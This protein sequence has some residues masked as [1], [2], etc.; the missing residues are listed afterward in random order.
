MP[1]TL[2]TPSDLTRDLDADHQPKKAKAGDKSGALSGSMSGSMSGS[3]SDTLSPSKGFVEAA[4]DST[5]GRVLPEQAQQASTPSTKQANRYVGRGLPPMPKIGLE[6]DQYLK[7]AKRAE[8]SGDDLLHEV[9]KVG[10]YVTLAVRRPDEKWKKK[11][12]FFHHALKRHCQA[13]EHADEITKKW[14]KKLAAFVRHH[15]GLEALRI[16][17]EMNDCFNM[18]VEMGQSRDDIADDAEEFFESVCPYCDTC[19]PLYNEAEWVEL[20]ALRDEWV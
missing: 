13:P 3:I 4:S 15:A 12:K 20:K 8:A 19:P 14:F 11:I 7:V 9:A 1:N 16:A 2:D 5:V 17:N 18:R 10:Q 6:E